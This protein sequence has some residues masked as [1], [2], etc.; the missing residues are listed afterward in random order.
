MKGLKIKTK[1]ML[2]AGSLALCASLGMAYAAVQH[3]PE[4]GQYTPTSADTGTEIYSLALSTQADFDLC[5]VENKSA[6]KWTFYKYGPYVRHSIYAMD[7]SA[8]DDYLIVSGISMTAGKDYTIS[9]EA[10][11]DATPDSYP[12]SIEFCYG[13]SASS[14]ALNA[15]STTEITTYGFSKYTSEKFTAPA[16]GTF[17]IALHANAPKIDSTTGYCDTKVRNIVVTEYEGEGGVV[18][19]VEPIEEELVLT[20]PFSTEDEFTSCTKLDANADNNTWKYYK[21]GPYVRYSSWLDARTDADDYLV[22]PAVNLKKGVEYEIKAELKGSDYPEAIAYCYATAPEVAAMNIVS[23]HN[24]TTADFAPVASSRFTVNV[25]GTYYIAVKVCSPAVD[26]NIGQHEVCMRN[27]TL[28]GYST[29]GGDDPVVEARNIPFSMTPTY[30][31]LDDIVIID[32]NEDEYDR[33]AFQLGVWNYDTAN[34][35]LVY[36]YSNSHQAA[37][38][39][40]VLPLLHFDNTEKAYNFAIDAK[41]ASSR[42]PESFEVYI[43][44]IY[45]PDEMTKIYS[46]GTLTNDE[47]WATHNI[48]F[49]VAEAGD[50]YVA[51][52]A[53]SEKDQFKLYVKNF[54]ITLTETSV[55]VPSKAADVVVAP[56][57]KGALKAIVSFAIPSTNIVGTALSGEVS[58]K[59]ASSIEEKT[60]SGQPGENKTVEVATAQGANIITVSAFNANGFGESLNE[61]VYTGVDV[62]RLPVVTSTVSEDNMTLHITWLADE[63]GVNGGYVDT[64][65]TVYTVSRYDADK[66]EYDDGTAFT[67]QFSYD[68][69]C[70]EGSAQH[71]ERFMIT[72]ENIAGREAGMGSARGIIGKPIAL[73]MVETI[74]N[75]RQTYSPLSTEV[76]NEQDYLYAADFRLYS[77]SSIFESADENY[78]DITVGHDKALWAFI[79]YGDPGRGRFMFPK[80]ST[81][82]INEVKFRM[83]VFMNAIFPS[84]T[85]YATAYGKEPVKIGA[86]AASDKVGWTDFAFVLPEEFGN[87]KWV[88]IFFESDFTDIDAQNIFI[89]S[90]TIGELLPNDIAIIALDG[91]DDAVHVGE[92]AD[93]TATV[94]NVGKNASVLPTVVFEVADADNNIIATERVGYDMDMLLS[95]E[96]CLDYTFFVDATAD[97]IGEYTVRAYLAADDDNPTNDL[98]EMVLTIAKG[99]K[100]II[101][102]LTAT[103]GETGTIH[104]AWSKPD[105]KLTG[106][107]DFE[108]Y[109]PFFYGK[110]IGQFKNIDGDKMATYSYD[111]CVFDAATKAK[112]FMV[113]NP[114][115]LSNRLVEENYTPRS[116]SQ[117]LVAFCPKD[118]SKADDWL[119][120]PEVKGGT[121]IS[122]YVSIVGLNDYAERY[123]VCYSSTTNDPA[124]FKVLEKC[125]AS[126]M[127]WQGK[128]FM[129]PDDARYFAI[130]YTSS[131]VFGIMIDDID[132][133]PVI[134]ERSK[135]EY[136]VYADDAIVAEGLAE[137]A[138]THT[139]LE[140]REYRYNVTAKVDGI[141][142]SYSNTVTAS[143]VSGLQSVATVRSIR[144]AQNTITI[145]GYEGEEFAI[146][147]VDGRCVASSKASII[148]TVAVEAGIYVVKAASDTAKVI[149]K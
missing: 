111:Q 97:I 144:A 115:Y 101:D 48:P 128:A 95:S 106:Y 91:P 39:Y 55:N 124:D 33:G 42:N 88:S 58:V 141:E 49:G 56:G 16:S 137:T 63:T 28:T 136:N 109:E 34:E 143:A 71:E 36:F 134:N 80:F 12:S 53:T 78:P 89:S 76:P 37:D 117:Y 50:Y 69:T 116:G 19:P 114:E 110:Y 75:G 86:I 145:S 77:L 38:D 7:N 119:I 96:Q 129:L 104:L 64:A 132:F 149:L 126:E 139:G 82:G 125:T 13:S 20:V 108:S 81:E 112:A 6:G 105:M 23:T 61:S 68:Y 79:R 130:H 1:M 67:G 40:V 66:K 5:T 92:R 122:F 83:N 51:V 118:G 22:L 127:K 43:G 17:C 72:A 113:I 65:T 138:Y 31:E 46:S 52:R 3:S 140:P 25:N 62:P 15:V 4:L 2:A 102:N 99:Q 45:T 54:N 100:P 74:E 98:Q 35:A 14:T 121:V 120:S 47:D 32:N 57:E 133:T 148:E 123:E 93:Y 18:T 60:V 24:I 90:Y 70:A 8:C 146:Y 44:K 107:D 30:A 87:C 9:V 26:S 11:K 85:F 41:V 59:V 21:Y 94:Q 29:A 131:D 10:C 103:T 73:P 135:F 142:H 27:L 84:T 147:T